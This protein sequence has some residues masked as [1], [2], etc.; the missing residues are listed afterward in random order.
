MSFETT[1]GIPALFTAGDAATFEINDSVHPASEWSTTAIIYFKDETGAIKNFNRTSV[2]GDIHVFALTGTNTGTLVAGRN[3]VCIAFSDG[4][5][6]QVSDWQETLVL[7][8]PTAV[9]TPSFAQAQVTLLRA[10]IVRLH[11]AG[12]TSVNF[13]GQS[14]TLAS[15][16]Q[17]ESLLTQWEATLL[18]EKD[19]ERADRGLATRGR[20]ALRFQQP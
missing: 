19:Q 13:N 11:T 4:T 1:Q 17:L 10:L 15:A 7:A 3:L 20:I 14:F 9:A 12:A 5:H 16:N 18:R 8:D 6:R 2:S